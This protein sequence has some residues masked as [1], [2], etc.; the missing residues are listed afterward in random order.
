MFYCPTHS[1]KV[2]ESN[3]AIYFKDELDSGNQIPYIMTFREEDVVVPLIPPLTK[4]S[5]VIPQ[6]NPM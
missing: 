6:I 5:F 1:T 2:I 4:S 3:M